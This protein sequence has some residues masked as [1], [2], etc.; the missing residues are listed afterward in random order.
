MD[1]TAG[2]VAADDNYLDMRGLIYFTLLSNSVII[3]L[4][5]LLSFAS[6]G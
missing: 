3:S 4:L 1:E 5:R 2:R 6:Y